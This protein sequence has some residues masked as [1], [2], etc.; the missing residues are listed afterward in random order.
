MLHTR[1]IILTADTRVQRSGLRRSLH[2]VPPQYEQQLHILLYQPICHRFQFYHHKNKSELEKTFQS[3]CEFLIASSLANKT[4]FIIQFIPRALHKLIHCIQSCK[5]KLHFLCPS[6]R[7]FLSFSWTTPNG[8]GKSI[9][10]FTP[11]R[12]PKQGL[13]VRICFRPARRGCG[14]WHTC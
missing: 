10:P 12:K 9:A 4:A 11:C 3:K 6:P 8:S 1:E 7:E 5:V 2:T 13:A 14:G